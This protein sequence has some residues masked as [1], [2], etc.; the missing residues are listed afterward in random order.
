MCWETIGIYRNV[1][2]SDVRWIFRSS[3]LGQEAI[4]WKNFLLMMS[5]GAVFV[6]GIYLMKRFGT[7]IEKNEKEVCNGFYIN[8][9]CLH[10]ALASPLMEVSIS[11]IL[12][13]FSGIYPSTE[14]EVF[15]GGREA[16]LNRLMKGMADVAILPDGGDTGS[17]EGLQSYTYIRKTDSLAGERISE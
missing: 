7:F 6:F 8:E 11:K 17:F 3:I 10:I 4:K 12:D 9:D 1:S 16:V 13:K 5:V 15:T 14:I 2:I